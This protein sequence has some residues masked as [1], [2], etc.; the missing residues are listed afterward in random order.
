MLGLTPDGQRAVLVY[1]LMGRSENSRNRVFV[2]EGPILKT[3]AHD[4]DKMTDPTLVIYTAL[5]LCDSR[6]IVTNG[7]H[8]DTLCEAFQRG[9]TFEQVMHSRCYE[10]DAPHFTPRI[11][12]IITIDDC[13]TQYKFSIL[14]KGNGADCLRFF[15]HYMEPQPGEGHLLHTYLGNSNPL[16]IFRGEPICLQTSDDINEFAREFWAALNEEN[17]VA[18][19]VRYI[20]LKDFPSMQCLTMDRY[21][22]EA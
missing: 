12:G 14:K 7:D 20:S 3:Q 9:G 13:H 1:F 4:P 19:H 18:L 15:Y 6:L 10:P 17:R 16:P 2:D 22:T 8:T 21:N 5:R 11:S